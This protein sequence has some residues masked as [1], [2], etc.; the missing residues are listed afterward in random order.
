MDMKRDTTSG[1]IKSII[2]NSG[3]SVVKDLLNTGQT[4]VDSWVV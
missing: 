1:S 3:T 2:G 4:E